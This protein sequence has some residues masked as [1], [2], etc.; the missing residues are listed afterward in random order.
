MQDIREFTNRISD[1]SGGFRQAQILFVAT[2]ADLFS[3]LEESPKYAGEVAEARGWDARGTRMLLDGLVA[4]GLVEKTGGQYRNREIASVCLVPGRDAYQGNIIRHTRSGWA[5]WERLEE[6]VRTG[7]GVPREGGERSPDELRDFILGMRN[8]GLL[9]ARDVLGALDLSRYRHVLDVGGGPGTYAIAFLKAHPGMKATLFDLPDVIAIA[10]EQ[11]AA[12]GLLERF[13]FLPGNYDTDSLGTGYDLVFV[14]NIIHSLGEE[15]NR[16]LA[17][18][19]H[20]A[21]A[22]GGTLVIKDFL[23]DEERTGPSFSLIFALHMLIH[24]G[25]G[26]TYTASQVADW[27]RAAGFGEGRLISITPQTRLWVTEKEA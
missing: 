27:T 18:K 5:T 16:A 24:A 10:R 9:S 15:R 13:S 4:L 22:P 12:A 20:A 2:E 25:E 17:R 21:L 26:D 14:S 1:I 11:V 23:V 7:T 6:S 8:I 19:C 3:L